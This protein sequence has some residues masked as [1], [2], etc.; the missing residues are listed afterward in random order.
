MTKDIVEIHINSLIDLM[1]SE[2]ESVL[3]NNSIIDICKQTVDQIGLTDMRRAI[4]S[5]YGS[6]SSVFK[7]DFPREHILFTKIFGHTLWAREEEI[8]LEI[9]MTDMIGGQ[10]GQR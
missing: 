8:E 6:E 9:N 5:Y 10:N 1:T 4:I 3:N 7:E 2:P